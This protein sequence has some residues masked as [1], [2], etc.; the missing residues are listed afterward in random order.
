MNR[1]LAFAINQINANRARRAA[2]IASTSGGFD[3]TLTTI[4]AGFQISPATTPGYAYG[5]VGSGIGVTSATVA[6]FFQHDLY[7]P[8]GMDG[9][10]T[11]DAEVT[12]I[13][14]SSPSR[15]LGLC[16]FRIDDN[17]VANLD[18]E[19]IHVEAFGGAPNRIYTR[20]TSIGSNVYSA[21]TNHNNTAVSANWVATGPWGLRI[22]F[23]GTNLLIGYKLHDNSWLYLTS[24]A[25]TAPELAEFTGTG[26]GLHMR[27]TVG[28][29]AQE[30][31]T[32]KLAAVNTLW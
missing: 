30:F 8:T 21:L 26:I 12:G 5:V 9:L 32:I 14:G 18:Q 11:F 27:A 19:A 15:Y 4:P 24:F 23:D 22:R 3:Y 10:A 29:T 17:H 13:W 7:N 28:T 20:K 31:R 25:L 1:R 2:I 6:D 16:L